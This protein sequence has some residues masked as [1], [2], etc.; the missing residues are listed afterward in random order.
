ML[1]VTS[2]DLNGQTDPAVD[3]LS[4]SEVCLGEISSFTDN[5]LNAVAVE[6]DF[7]D[8]DFDGTSLVNLVATLPGMGRTLGLDVVKFDGYWYGFVTSWNQNRLYRLRFGYG[9]TQSPTEIVDMG[10]PSNLLNQPV[11]IKVI[12][13]ASKWYILIHNWGNSTISRIDIGPSLLDQPVSG[14]NMINAVGGFPA[15]MEVLDGRNEL[16]A[17]V[18]QANGSVRIIDFKNDPELAVTGS[19]VI[20]TLPISGVTSARDIA[21]IRENGNWV[22]FV[23]SFNPVRIYRLQFGSDVMNGVTSGPVQIFGDDFKGRIN[24]IAITPS[25]LGYYLHVLTLEGGLFK[26]NLADIG[27]IPSANTIVQYGQSVNYNEGYVLKFVKDEGSWHGLTFQDN[28]ANAPKLYEISSRFDCGESVKFSTEQNAVV[29]YTKPGVYPVTLNAI[30]ELGYGSSLSR[31]ITVINEKA[32]GIDFSLNSLC[33][34]TPVAFFPSSDQTLISHNWSFGDSYSSA[35]ERPSHQYASPGTYGVKVE[36]VSTNGCANFLEKEIQIYGAPVPDFDIPPGLLCTNNE[37]MFDA[38]TPDVFDGNLSYEWYVEGAL[39][40]SERYLKYDFPTTGPKAITLKTLIPGCSEELVKTIGPLEPGPIVDF[41]FT[42]SCQEEIF[43][44]KNEI[45]DPVESFVWNFGTGETTLDNDPA[46]TFPLAGEYLVSLSATNTTGC[47]TVKTKTVTVHSRPLV[48]FSAEGPPNA[49]SGKDTYFANATVNPDAQPITDWLWVFNDPRDPASANESNGAHI[50]NEAGTYNVSLTATTADGCVGSI[51]KEVT[52]YPS[53]S[54]DYTATAACEDL[55]VWFAS[56]PDPGI[57]A[58]YWEIGTSYYYTASPSHTFAVAGDYPLYAEFYGGNGCISTVERTIH[59]PVPLTPDFSVTRNCVGD[60]AVFTDVTAAIDPVASRSW[61]FADGLSSSSVTTSHI[62]TQQRTGPVTLQLTTSSGCSYKVTREIT[63]VQPPHAEFSA[64]PAQGAYP[65]EVTFTNSSSHAT[66]FLWEFDD[67]TSSASTEESPQYTFSEFGDFNVK[68]T[69]TNA[70][71]CENSFIQTI[72]AVAPLPDVEVEVINFV[73][74]PD[75]SG[76]LIVTIHN[77]GNTILKD[78]PVVLDFEGKLLMEETIPVAILPATPYNFIFTT[79]ILNHESLRYLCVSVALENDLMPED[80]RSCREFDEELYV[81]PAYPNP[82]SE[83]V[84]LE[85][86]STSTKNVRVSLQDAV[87]RTVFRHTL[88][89]SSGLNIQNIDVTALP[90]G[91][92]FLMT[93]DGT[94]KNTQRIMILTGP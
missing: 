33:E 63:I 56:P 55:P 10:N 25:A 47:E 22:A 62:F 16:K 15:K 90:D 36:V 73:P 67:G 50:Y 27:S 76:K 80:N 1:F 49:C 11:S 6:W 75:G 53:P 74:N 92:Y 17:S 52:I 29:T 9:L 2:L 65:L 48:D 3:F 70:Q 69:A 82:A 77:K 34:L 85:W 20:N 79:S 39:V 41:S 91:V 18:I 40:G 12:S 8:K 19:D 87:G 45:A 81:L 59:V 66:S 42:G 57:Q 37:L 23:S 13:R 14:V 44:F 83:Q 7:C 94:S 5:S 72:S 60:D 24:N 71:Q 30:D 4:K 28:L 32:P 58:W 88:A 84:T 89:T 21:F 35:L 61:T 86:I 68:L 26:V 31:E 78:L 51:D 64:S 38:I 46:Y 54:I 93:D 43:S